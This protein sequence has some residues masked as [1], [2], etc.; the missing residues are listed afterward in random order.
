M[1]ELHYYDVAKKA[2]KKIYWHPGIKRISQI[3][4]KSRFILDVGCGEGTKLAKII[5]KGKDATGIDISH[6]AIQKAKKQFPNIKFIK[7]KDEI[8]P[9]TSNI[10]DLVYSTFVLEHTKNQELFIN[11]MIRV[12]AINGMI[13]IL[14]PNY[15]SPN[16]RSPVSIEQPLPKLFLGITKDFSFS[17]NN[18]LSF[19]KVTPKKIFKNPDDDT[20][21]EPYLYD[22]IKYIH[23][24]N[25]L[26]IIQSSSLWEIDDGVNSLHQRIFKFLGQ[27][28]TFPFKYWGPQ[29]FL[30]I[31]KLS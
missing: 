14:C 9:F 5:E 30:V 27:K 2:N 17:T 31:K 13:V 7:T 10:F 15:G 16:R 4:K 18:H 1:N 23:R 12:T 8:I 24:N 11:E 19:T 21:C 20:T 29:L 6:F 25:N 22:L 28:N 3:A 26:K